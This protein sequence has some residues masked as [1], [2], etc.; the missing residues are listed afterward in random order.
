MTTKV[1]IELKLGEYRARHT[2]KDPFGPWTD[3]KRLNE[4]LDLQEREILDQVLNE[5]KTDVFWG[6]FI[7][8]FRQERKTR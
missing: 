4:S 6:E 8:L 2:G 5:K 1:E 7:E 3:L